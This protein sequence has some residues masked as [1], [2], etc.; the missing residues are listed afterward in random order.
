MLSTQAID[1]DTKD[2]CFICNIENNKF[3]RRVEGG[4][5]E[6]VKHQHNM[7]EYLYFMH[8]LMRKPN[9]EFTGQESYVWGKMQRQ[10][11]SFFPLNKSLDYENAVQEDKAG[12]MEQMAT[13]GSQ[14]QVFAPPPHY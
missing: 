13:T 1:E 11:I 7:W 3:D 9:H 8:H 4:F 2:R 5:E 6:H 14:P 10:D 12:E